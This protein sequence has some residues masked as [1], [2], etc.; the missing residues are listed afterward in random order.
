MSQIYLFFMSKVYSTSERERLSSVGLI[1][2]YMV[3]LDARRTLGHFKNYFVSL[4]N[5]EEALIMLEV[6]CMC[7]PI[8]L[9]PS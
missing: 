4:T 1:W 3:L 8:F 7:V 5:L 9:V 6:C 2:P